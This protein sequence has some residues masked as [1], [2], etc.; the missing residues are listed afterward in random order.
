[1]QVH[2]GEELRVC[3]LGR[4]RKNEVVAESSTKDLFHKGETAAFPHLEESSSLHVII[5]YELLL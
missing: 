5:K 1:M 4:D 2:C 3:V